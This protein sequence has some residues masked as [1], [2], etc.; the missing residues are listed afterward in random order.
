MCPQV[1]LGKTRQLGLPADKLHFLEVSEN[2]SEPP[3]S[4]YLSWESN[5]GAWTAPSLAIT[6]RQRSYCSYEQEGQKKPANI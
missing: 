6:R 5:C 1:L 4:Q 2:L 3:K